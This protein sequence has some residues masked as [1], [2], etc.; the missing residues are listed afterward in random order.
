MTSEHADQIVMIGRS[1]GSMDKLKNKAGMLIKEIKDDIISRKNAGKAIYSQLEYLFADPGL[2]DQNSS[3]AEYWDYYNHM[4]GEEANIKI[5]TKLSSLRDCDVV[6]VATSDP[7]PF[8][9]KS[10]VKPGAFICDISVP[11][12]CD[13]ELLNHPDYSV[14]KGGIIKLPYGESLYPLGL[15]LEDGQAYACMVETLLM[16]FENNEGAYS[17]GEIEAMLVADLGKKM[18]NHGFEVMEYNVMM[19]EEI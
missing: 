7:K 16:G 19:K 4:F 18:L 2:K 15:G 17:Y 9:N 13:K 14:E 1:N 10:F 12:N 5:S 8:L 11:L 3:P 6:I